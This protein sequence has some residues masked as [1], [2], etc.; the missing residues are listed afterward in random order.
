VLA[1]VW[2][3]VYNIGVD[4]LLLAIGPHP[5]G[6]WQRAAHTGGSRGLLF[7]ALPVMSW[8]LDIS[9]LEALVLDLG[10][11]LFYLVYAFIYNW[12][13]DKVFPIPMVRCR[14]HWVEARQKTAGKTRHHHASGMM[15]LKANLAGFRLVP[16][17]LR[18]GPRP[19]WFL[20]IMASRSLWYWVSMSLGR[21]HVAL[22]QALEQM[23]LHHA[24]E[25]LHRDGLLEVSSSSSFS[26]SALISSAL[27][28]SRPA[29]CTN[30]RRSPSR[31]RLNMRFL[32]CSFCWVIHF[33]TSNGNKPAHSA[34]S[35]DSVHLGRM[36]YS[37]CGG[38]VLF[39]PRP[40]IVTADPGAR[41]PRCRDRPSL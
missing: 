26:S 29:S 36:T 12:S 34:L 37:G 8:W 3:Y 24:V 16:S 2:N 40:G 31:N 14:R 38:R 10:F 27:V 7:V 11:V 41:A 20:R 21:D 19:A 18:S 4:K 25:I 6:L 1:T 17:A 23:V 35:S 13:Y 5:Q 30:M 33:L 28:R 39:A 22:V 9:L 32:C 15:V